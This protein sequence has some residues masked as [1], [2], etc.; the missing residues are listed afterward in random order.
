MTRFLPALTH[1]KFI[2]FVVSSAVAVTAMTAPARADV[3]DF[4]KILAGITLLA[5]IGKAIDDDSKQRHVT[6]NTYHNHTYKNPN[7]P[8][9]PKPLPPQV[10][11][12]YDLPGHCLKTYQMNGR[13]TVR[14]FGR[15]CLQQSYRHTNSLP[16]ACQFQ[17]DKTNRSQTGYEP[18]CLRERGYRVARN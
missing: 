18:R 15:K 9:R 17:F 8:V 13:D 3:N 14:L 16:Y 10:S 1:R 11:S 12:R 4:G 7:Q 6:R 5:I 2:A